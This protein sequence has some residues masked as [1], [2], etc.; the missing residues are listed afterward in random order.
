MRWSRDDES[1]IQEAHGRVLYRHGGNLGDSE[2]S[3]AVDCPFL[4][5]K[6]LNQ[7][8][9]RDL[10]N[11]LLDF[12]FSIKAIAKAVDANNDQVTYSTDL[13]RRGKINVH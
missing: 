13:V 6:R 7:S 10:M 12:L 2:T 5:A 9:L 8:K 1:R 4:H 3:R 11:Q